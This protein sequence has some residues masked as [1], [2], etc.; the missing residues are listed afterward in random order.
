M[1]HLSTMIEC[2]RPQYGNDTDALFAA[3]LTTREKIALINPFLS[4]SDRELLQSQGRPDPYHENFYYLPMQPYLINGM[5]S[6]YFLDVSSIVAPLMLPIMEGDR[7]LDM[8]SAP[9]GKLLVML[10]RQIPSA[11]FV[12]NDLSLTRVSRLR[13]VLH[14]FLPEHDTRVSIMNR[15][16][17]YF[18][19]KKPDH[20]NAVLLDAPCSSEAH[21]AN[22]PT[23]AAAF[24][25]L[26]KNLPY[27]QYAMLAA[28]LLTTK[29]GGYIMYSTCS[30]NHHENDGVIEKLLKKKSASVEVISLA[31][32]LGSKT[33]HGV[34]IL[35]HLHNAGP[36]YLSLIY[37]K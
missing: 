31:P 8:A 14:D 35:P 34:A 9:G 26:S 23:L 28:A 19:L 27:R 24:Q 30:I 32:K 4:Q 25:N 12:A 22:D 7:V 36:A 18:G 10:S 1:N 20:F 11:T 16:G 15:D 3:M 6:H 33:K 5:L 21:V 17:N 2:Y 29:S 37:K 13:R